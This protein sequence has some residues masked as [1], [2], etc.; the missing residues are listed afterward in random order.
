MSVSEMARQEEESTESAVTKRRI[1]FVNGPPRSGKDTVGEL[2]K[3]FHPGTVYVTKF[4]KLLKERTH[5]LY[6]LVDITDNTPLPHDFFEA[7]KDSAHS[8][9]MGLSPRQAYIN[10]AE[11]LF[12]PVHGREIFG[13]LLLEDIELHGADADLVVVT[14]SGFEDEIYPVADKFFDV[15]EESEW[16]RSD[17]VMLL[18]MHRAGTTFE[19]DSR[20]YVVP[21]DRRIAHWAVSNNGTKLELAENLAQV[22]PNLFIRY[23]V[24]VQLPSG[25]DLEWF[26]QGDSTK[27][28]TLEQARVVAEWL[29]SNGYG[30]RVIR[31]VAGNSIIVQQIMPGDPVVTTLVPNTV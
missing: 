21:K 26:P 6:G 1:L 28:T 14:D 22:V 10:V 20:S 23:T 12:R 17:S 9:F 4:A 7:E 30:Q 31:I 2:I 27:R 16:P 3:E 13:K 25:N 19:G 11:Q 5:A 29:R 8:G 18:R 24:E 15:S